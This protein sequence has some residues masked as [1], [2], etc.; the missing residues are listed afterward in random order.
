MSGV[1][2]L[3]VLT[4]AGLTLEL[5]FYRVGDKAGLVDGSLMVPES[6]AP[7]ALWL[8]RQ[9][10][11]CAPAR[12]HTRVERNNILPSALWIGQ[13]LIY[14]DAATAATVQ[15]WLDS[16]HAPA[17]QPLPATLP[18]TL[19]AIPMPGVFA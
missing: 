15:A 6:Q 9:A 13:A 2:K 3:T 17:L 8:D 5:S 16:R 11:F 19:P 18:A 4:V 14:L 10:V 12:A 7:D 1:D